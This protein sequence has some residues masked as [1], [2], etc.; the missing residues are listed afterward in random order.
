MSPKKIKRCNIFSREGKIL[1]RKKVRDEV[2]SKI[3]E[4]GVAVYTRKVSRRAEPIQFTEAQVEDGIPN[5][6]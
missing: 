3:V 4:Q 1:N 6:L 5:Q 2:A